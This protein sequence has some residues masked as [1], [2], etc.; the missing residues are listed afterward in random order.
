[1]CEVHEEFTIADLLAIRRSFE[2]PKGHSNR[3]LYAHWECRREVLREADFYG[4]TSQ[5]MENIAKR[6]EEHRLERAF[7]ASECELTSNL[8]QEF[9]SVQFWTACSVRC[10]HMA[11]VNLRKVLNVIEAIDVGDDL[12]NYEVTLR[13][14]VIERARAPIQRMLE[15]SA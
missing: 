4:S 13:P 3:R 7:V 1:V 15:M 2:I 10:S 8:A 9:P 12:S 5:I 11:K 6:V 14:D